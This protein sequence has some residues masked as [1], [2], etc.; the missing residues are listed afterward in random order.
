MPITNHYRAR[1]GTARS[2][3]IPAG[4]TPS[5]PRSTAVART[6]RYWWAP[7]S[8]IGWADSD[9]PASSRRH[10]AD[11]GPADGHRPRSPAADADTMV[12]DSPAAD[13]PPGAAPEPGPMEGSET[14]DG[15]AAA[16]P[17]V[18]AAIGTDTDGPLPFPL[19]VTA[20]LVGEYRWIELALYTLLGRWVVDVPLAAV[21]VHLDAQSMR[22]AWHAELWA[23]RLP[24]LPGSDP[25]RAD[26]SVAAH[27]H[28]VRRRSGRPSLGRADA[29]DSSVAVPTD[30]DGRPS[31]GAAPI[32]PAST[33]W[34]CPASSSAT[35]VIW[36]RPLTR[37]TDPSS[38]R[39]AWCSTTRSRT[40]T[41]GSGWSSVS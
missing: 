16:R 31:R 23:E 15:R 5:H 33:G 34:S 40:G 28:S 14:T 19:A 38:G 1:S 41:P 9:R 32:W 8:P 3:R 22:H 13:A 24:V 27:R 2:Y 30:A 12:T 10:R 29:G 36:R 37:P 7:S 20:A 39:C 17:G 26:G 11:G 6:P 4:P 21:Q 25:D 18:A 35:S